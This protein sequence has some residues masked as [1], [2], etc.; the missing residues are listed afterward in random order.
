LKSLQL[1][2]GVSLPSGGAMT[3]GGG[4][5]WSP[6][7]IQLYLMTDNISSADNTNRIHFQAGLNIV[8]RKKKDESV[9]ETTATPE[10]P[11]PDKPN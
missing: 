3:F 11:K 10:P 8:L 9:P 4:F 1:S 2:G 6:G 5:V 7:P